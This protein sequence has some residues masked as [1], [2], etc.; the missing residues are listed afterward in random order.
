MKHSGLI[1]NLAQKLYKTNSRYDIDDL[2]QVG[3]LT[4]INS[5]PHYDSSKAKES[6]YFHICIF[7]AMCR[8]IK[9]NNKFDP[10][11]ENKY[12]IREEEKWEVLPDLHEQDY[13]V[14]CMKMDGHSNKA[15]SEQLNMTTLGV[16]LSWERIINET[17]KNS[18]S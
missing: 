8:F 13:Q 1:H 12:S 9:K 16:K 3:Y 15:I 18:C 17:Q 4:Y 6:T 10:F 5:E 7:R 14:A 2:I 11:E